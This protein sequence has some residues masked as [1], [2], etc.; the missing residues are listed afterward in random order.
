MTHRETEVLALI[1]QGRSNQ[2]IAEE[3]VLSLNS[4]KSYIRSPAYRKIDVTSLSEAVLWGVRHG[5]LSRDQ[6]ATQHSASVR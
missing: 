3:L 6:D 2:D 1:S 5:L 4:I